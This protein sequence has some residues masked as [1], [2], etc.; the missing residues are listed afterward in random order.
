MI[1]HFCDALNKYAIHE[2]N[3]RTLLK[4]IRSD[5]E[6]LDRLKKDRR[7]VG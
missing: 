5:E 2:Q 7:S 6:Y 4:R 1:L 3:I